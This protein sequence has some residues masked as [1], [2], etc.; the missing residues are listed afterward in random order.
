MERTHAIDLIIPVYN[1]SELIPDLIGTLEGQR[2]RDFRV[3]FVDDGSSDNSFEVLR[4]SLKTVSFDYRVVQQKNKGPS[5][6]RNFGIKLA[7]AEWIAFMDSDDILLPEY[8][9]YLLGA[10]KGKDVQMGYCRLQIIPVGDDTPAKSAGDLH[11]RVL[12]SEEA[13]RR[14]YMNWIA[15]VCLILNRQWVQRNAL[16]FDEGCRYCEDLMFITE[17][18]D[19]AD[20]VSESDNQLYVYRTHEGSL[21]RS[22]NT[23]K[24]IDGLKGFDRLEEKL[25]GSETTAA[26]VFFEMG[27]ARFLLGIF[28]RAALQLDRKDFLKLAK[29]VN[30]ESCAHQVKRLPAKQRIAGYMYRT[31]R[32]L[33]YYCSR[34]L[35]S[36]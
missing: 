33:F 29:I 11:Y 20:Q 12:S 28:R 4:E 7:E 31:S 2:M 15:P 34:M 24:Y 9:E 25:R 32:L 22:S 35:F 17:C 16:F 27:R 21:L 26:R 19:A 13:M 36:D 6:A 18:I 5:A 30:F 8:L 14:H 10:V 1:R 3:I 23:L